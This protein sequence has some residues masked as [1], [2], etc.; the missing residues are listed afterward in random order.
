MPR[1]SPRAR[2][3]LLIRGCFLRFESFLVQN[4]AIL[5][6]AG[7]SLFRGPLK[8]RLRNI[9]KTRAKTLS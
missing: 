1:P 3:R 4:C 5:R 7:V 2:E 6:T 9:A 8:N